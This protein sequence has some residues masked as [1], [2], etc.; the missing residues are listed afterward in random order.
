MNWSVSLLWVNYLAA[1]KQK[2]SKLKSSARLA[3]CCVC[4]STDESRLRKF[5]S[6]RWNF[7]PDEGERA[8]C[9]EGVDVKGLRRRDGQLSMM[10]VAPRL[11]LHD[12]RCAQ[13]CCHSD[14][15]WDPTRLAIHGN[16]IRLQ[17]SKSRGHYYF[18]GMGL[19]PILFLLSEYKLIKMILF[20]YKNNHLTRP[21]IKRFYL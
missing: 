16:W 12:I 20:V 21:I 2:F 17:R 11:P 3:R 14:S 6:W 15:H 4:V 1:L 8:L 18:L 10:R 5:F 13:L 19:R 7:M 9:Q